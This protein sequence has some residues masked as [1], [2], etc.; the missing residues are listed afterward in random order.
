[1]DSKTIDFACANIFLNIL[2]GNT[3]S[4]LIIYEKPLDNLLELIGKTKDVLK[5]YG[6][7][8]TV[9]GL[10]E[11]LPIKFNNSDL[12]M[13]V[14]ERC[15]KKDG[16]SNLNLNK[17]P[18]DIAKDIS[19]I[20]KIYSENSEN[21]TKEKKEYIL[22]DLK[23]V[24]DEMFIKKLLSLSPKDLVEHIDAWTS[25]ELEDLFDK[26]KQPKLDPRL[27]KIINDYYNPTEE[28]N[29]SMRDEYLEKID[30]ILTKRYGEKKKITLN[31]YIFKLGMDDVKYNG[32]FPPS[33]NYVRSYLMPWLIWL[34]MKKYPKKFKNLNADNEEFIYSSFLDEYTKI[35]KL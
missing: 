2:N 32:K 6:E 10:P 4:T 29:K 3:S 11:D 17:P 33:I 13:D 18:L 20:M 15:L 12:G 22:N 1:M 14:Y 16:W 21:L 28:K 5:G 7:K 34:Y 26:V 9:N 35:K 24:N 25:Y 31:D 8:R 19:K 27:A 23:K 30:A